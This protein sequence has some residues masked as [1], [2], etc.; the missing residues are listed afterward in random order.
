[1]FLP[2]LPT[3]QQEPLKMIQTGEARYK[4]CIECHHQFTS[5]NVWTEKGWQET[6]NSGLCEDCFQEL[7]RKKK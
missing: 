7:V 4:E 1:M 2:T 6:Q 3:N 5:R